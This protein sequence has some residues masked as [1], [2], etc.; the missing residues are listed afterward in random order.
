MYPCSILK[1]EFLPSEFFENFMLHFHFTR[2]IAIMHK[3]TTKVCKLHIVSSK[4]T[5][6]SFHGWTLHLQIGIRV[7]Y[8]YSKVDI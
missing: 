5:L 4:N 8:T 6:D 7:I 3:S 2:N 1:F